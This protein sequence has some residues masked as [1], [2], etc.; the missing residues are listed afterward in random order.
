MENIWLI[1]IDRAIMKED[2]CLQCILIFFNNITAEL[3]HDVTMVTVIL[4]SGFHN[5]IRNVYILVNMTWNT[6]IIGDFC[7]SEIETP[8]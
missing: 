3:N 7:L 2:V 5:F 8:P 6:G 1:C 4:Y